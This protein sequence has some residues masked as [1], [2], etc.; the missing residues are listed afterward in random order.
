MAD[1]KFK[2]RKLG[3]TELFDPAE[4]ELLLHNIN[5][6]A[7][8]ELNRKA[9]SGD[10]SAKYIRRQMRQMERVNRTRFEQWR[11]KRIIDIRALLG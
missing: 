5:A 4:H 1:K 8:R 6:V 11:P 2:R 7:N 9:D 3:S 10:E